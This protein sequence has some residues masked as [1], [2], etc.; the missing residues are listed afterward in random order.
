MLSAFPGIYSAGRVK[1][2]VNSPPNFRYTTGTSVGCLKYNNL[3]LEPNFHEYK[4]TKICCSFKLSWSC[5]I[6]HLSLVKTLFEKKKIVSQKPCDYQY[7]YV[8]ILFWIKNMLLK[9]VSG[10]CLFTVLC[11]TLKSGFGMCQLNS[12]W[13]KLKMCCMSAHDALLLLMGI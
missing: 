8:S 4:I 6:S 9:E 7:V 11:F 2:W 13:M 1:F 3:K 5:G 12:F 10:S